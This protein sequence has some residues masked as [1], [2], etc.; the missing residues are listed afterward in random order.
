[1]KRIAFTISILF[2]GLTSCKKEVVEKSNSPAVI[3]LWEIVQ[4]AT[5]HEFGYLD[6]LDQ[7]AELDK[8]VSSR[9]TTTVDHQNQFEVLDISKTSMTWT[10]PQSETKLYNWEYE[11]N[12]FTLTGTDTIKYHVT[13]LTY[14]SFVFFI[15]DLRPYSD[16][17][18]LYAYEEYQYVYH[19]NK[20]N[21]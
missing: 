8:V 15:K 13:E 7:D 19:L 4:T 5:T 16:S 18:N 6:Y 20:V 11:N 12:Q 14:D 17:T 1:M 10:D 21:D 9:V 2:I 3:G